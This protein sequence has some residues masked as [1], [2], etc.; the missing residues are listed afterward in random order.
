MRAPATRPAPRAAPQGRS[1]T[2]TARELGDLR[3]RALLA[4]DAW[5]TLPADVR[6]RFSKRLR[7]GESVVYAGRASAF[8]ANFAGRLLAQAMRLVGAP[9]PLGGDLGVATVVIVTEDAASGGQVWT[10]CY[11][12][13]RGFPQVIHS[14]KRFSGPTGL[15][16]HIGR[17]VSMSLTV[18]VERRA[19]VFRSAAYFLAL[20]PWRV[21]L[22]RWLSPGALRVAHEETGAGRFRFTLALVHPLF[23]ELLYQAGDYRDVEP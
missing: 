13:R 5:A 22:P 18:S 16:E 8:R 9:L 17:G 21:R 4:E 12:N 7:D 15:E 14:A 10:R 20:G 1:P 23:G 11:A 19:L 2:R 3:F 6:R